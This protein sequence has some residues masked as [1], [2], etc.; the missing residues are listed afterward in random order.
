MR[1]QQRH[2]YSILVLVSYTAIYLLL[3]DIT[4]GVLTSSYLAGSR[5]DPAIYL[6]AT[7]HTIHSLNTFHLNL[8]DSNIFYPYGKALAYSDNYILPALISYIALQLTNALPLAMNIPL[9]LAAVLNGFFTYQLSLKCTRSL[10]AAY[11]AG[12]CFML[13]PYFTFHAGHPQLQYAFFFP[14]IVLAVLTYC[15]KRT[16]LSATAIGLCVFLS[17]LCA[18]YY[19]LYCYLLVCVLFLTY[20]ILRPKSLDFRFFTTLFIA[21]IPWLILTFIAAQPY[22][23][24]R[25]AFGPQHISLAKNYSATLLSY[26]SAPTR[27]YAWGGLTSGFTHYESYLFPGSLILILCAFEVVRYLRKASKAPTSRLDFLFR[28]LLPILFSLLLV[29]ELILFPGFFL[30]RLH[31]RWAVA[32]PFWI[33]LLI[34]FY[35]LMRAQKD[36]ANPTS[37]Q[38]NSR[39]KELALFFV[40]LIFLFSSLGI[41]G[42]HSDKV[43]HPELYYHLYHYLPGFNAMRATSRIGL[44][45]DLLLIIL[46]SSGIA[47]FDYR[48][49]KSH[50]I[51][52]H[53]GYACILFLSL[54]EL[55]TAH[56][57]RTGEP[58]IPQIYEYLHSME[59]KS[60]AISLPFHSPLKD[61]LLYTRSQTDYMRWHQLDE[62]R[63]IVNGFSGKMPAYHQHLGVQLEHFP[64]K[65]SLNSLS[66]IVGLKY[67]VVSKKY[68]HSDARRMR[69]KKL[70]KPYTD[71]LNFLHHEV[72]GTLL[73]LK[74][75]FYLTEAPHP[76]LLL[77]ADTKHP[78]TLRFLLTA[79]D[80]QPSTQTQPSRPQSLEI[81]VTT[82]AIFD[83]SFFGLR[84]KLVQYSKEQIAVNIN[85]KKHF[86]LHIPPSRNAV[87]AHRIPFDISG[88]PARYELTLSDIEL[89]DEKSAS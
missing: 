76:E 38:L 63:N 66:Q 73:E 88:I 65:R 36:T 57:K 59:D 28:L 6:W 35:A 78:R 46:A 47:Y 43:W 33:L 74:P 71:Q 24:V 45:A 70:I 55:Q 15:E 16:L 72:D 69:L 39:D 31:L 56:A 80:K 22:L 10:K 29:T 62:E 89:L 54:F 77:P 18:V 58:H 75:K 51:F 7:E 21:N 1:H 2:L 17:F 67:I 12:L 19:S 52:A 81:S 34:A 82:G 40:L 30:T 68:W 13:L 60:P 83:D 3:N 48:F 32:L 61:S 27:N 9:I 64:D 53:G 84:T 44:I 41:I 8:Y 87:K 42:T 11:L 85:S 20:F 4:L 50:R 79:T 86:E 37:P 5:G 26:L 14:A 49:R 25:S 23:E